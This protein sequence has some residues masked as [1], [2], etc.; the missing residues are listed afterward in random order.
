MKNGGNMKSNMTEYTFPS[1]NEI[2]T[3]HCREWAPEGTPK[4]V[5]LV[6][7]D[8]AEH[9]GRY[10]DL[11]SYMTENGILVVGH[12]QIGHGKSSAPE[13]RGYFGP[14]SGWLGM[15]Y[16]VEEHRKVIASRHPGVPVFVLGN[17]MGSYIARI[18]MSEF[19][20]DICGAVIMG[21]A[22][23]RKTVKMEASLIEA[24]RK[25]KGDRF[26]SPMA[27]RLV[28]GHC[29]DRIPDHKTVC[30]WLTRDDEEVKRYMEDPAC[31]FT[32]TAAGFSDLFRLLTYMGSERCYGDTVTDIPVLVIS[33]EEDPMG[34]FG[35]GPEEYYEKMLSLGCGKISLKLY[36]GMRH[37]ILHELGKEEVYADIRDFVL[38]GL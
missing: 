37:D 2:D 25:F 17:S 26:I 35:K 7:H 13:D 38:G 3:I 11:A 34:S 28:F 14:K 21:T 27:A 4:A 24:T 18:Y 8:M 5:L 1:V 12:D 29:L 22:G 16:D 30:D 6:V 20:D 10:E 15:I 9:M 31:G 32:F 19:G 36:P 33:G 23:S